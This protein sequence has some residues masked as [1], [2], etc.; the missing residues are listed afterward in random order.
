MLQLR[1]EGLS[2]NAI[3]ETIHRYH[4]IRLYSPNIRDWV[5]GIRGP[6]GNVNK[7]DAGPS[8]E[9]AY[10]IGVKAGDGYLYKHEYDYLFG[11]NTIDYEFAAETGRCLAILLGRKEPYKPWWDRSGRR[12]RVLCGSTLLYSFLQQ[13]W[14]KLRPY[15]EHCRDC[16]AAFLR[17]FFDGEG[18]VEPRHLK[19]YN[20]NF[21]LLRY[22]R[23][24]LQQYFGIE[25]TGPS[26]A[27]DCYYV[28][29]RAPGLPLFHRYIDFT[30]KRKQRR[31]VESIQK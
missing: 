20:T 11:L 22:I 23:F 12:W 21:E 7:F 13:P 31:L 6:L 2:W 18:S 29:V 26:R 27:K 24:L 9:L 1:G 17:A 16:V 28:Y 10:I 4:G 25:T 14:Q 3:I 19:V 30:I 5:H 8:L 15:I